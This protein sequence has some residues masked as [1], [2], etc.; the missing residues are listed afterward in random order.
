MLLVAALELAAPRARVLL[1]TNCTRLQ[2][3]ALEAIARFALKATR[4]AADFHGEPALPDIPAEAAA[5]TLWLL[6]K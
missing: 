5:Q 1:S 3:R 4:R 6:L 2:R